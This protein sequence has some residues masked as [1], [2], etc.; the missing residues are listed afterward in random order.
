MEGETRQK[1]TLI[2]GLGN[3]LL[4]DDG[5]GLRIVRELRHRL[6]SGADVDLVESPEMGLALLDHIVGYQ[7]LVLVD[8]VKTGRVPA[9]T[10]H[11]LPLQDVDTLPLMAP[12]FFGIGEIML[13]GQELKLPMPQE[14][15]I[16]AIEVEDPFTIREALSPTLQAALP[17]LIELVW[18]AASSSC[19][20]TSQTVPLALETA[21]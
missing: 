11:E 3:D 12:H 19:A 4:G 16:R 17:S 1:P 8:A 14:V 13:L 15:L 6:A 21:N 10:V 2:L 5:I 18:Q 20:S 9:G 7:R